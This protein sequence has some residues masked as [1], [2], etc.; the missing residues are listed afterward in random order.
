MT[1]SPKCQISKLPLKMLR[2]HTCKPAQLIS[3]HRDLVCSQNTETGSI[4]TIPMKRRQKKNLRGCLSLRQGIPPRTSS[5]SLRDINLIIMNRQL[6]QGSEIRA[7][8]RLPTPSTPTSKRLKTMLS[9]SPTT[10]SDS[11]L[12]SMMIS[13]PLPEPRQ[14]P[15]RRRESQTTGLPMRDEFHSL[16]QQE[17]KDW[18]STRRLQNAVR[19]NV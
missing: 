10:M 3:W 8:H 9:H 5:I 15:I 12:E 7:L 17:I 14:K 1:S 16:F 2:M 11:R 19:V 4:T 13:S 18:A 6:P